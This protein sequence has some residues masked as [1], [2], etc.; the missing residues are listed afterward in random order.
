MDESYADQFIIEMGGVEIV[1]GSEESPTQSVSGDA[2]LASGYSYAEV[3]EA[4]KYA[5][6]IMG[7][8]AEVGKITYKL[9]EK[10]DL[11]DRQEMYLRFGLKISVIG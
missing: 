3:Q 2:A 8:A 5:A 1:E 4:R 10:I 6:E 7:L 11:F 9:I